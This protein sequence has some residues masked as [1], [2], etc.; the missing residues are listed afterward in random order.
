M[1]EKRTPE[2]ADRLNGAS[3]K[4][5]RKDLEATSKEQLQLS[6][7]VQTTVT[8]SLSVLTS[9]SSTSEYVLFLQFLRD[10]RCLCWACERLRT[11]VDDGVLQLSMYS[12]LDIYGREFLVFP[13]DFCFTLWR[14]RTFGSRR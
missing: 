6:P 12:R 10:R 5:R 11:E 9:T 13:Y 3:S 4:R 7:P 8:S 1:P 2:S 14:A